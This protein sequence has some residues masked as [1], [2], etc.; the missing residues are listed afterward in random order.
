[1]TLEEF[2]RLADTWGGDIERWP[3]PRRVEAGQ[4]AATEEGASILAG[5]QRLD[6]LLA[7]PSDIAPERAARAA[8]AVVQR[9][10][11]EGEAGSRQ[12][13]SHQGSSHQGSWI[14]SNWWMPAAS[15]AGSALIGISLATMMPY[16]GSDEPTIVL[17]AILDSGSMAASWVTR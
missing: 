9:I 1:M 5:A 17:S 8:F 13:A 2:R 14:L 16:G 3:A 10:A 11:A 6:A 7:K 15:V 12:G 4:C